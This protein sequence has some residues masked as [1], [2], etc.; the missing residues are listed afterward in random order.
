MENLVHQVLAGGAPARL[1]RFQ[2]A[3][4]GFANTSPQ[5]LSQA[6]ERYGAQ[7]QLQWFRQYLGA[8]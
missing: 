5:T 2:G 7:E 1:L 6:Y 8:E 4:H 3:S